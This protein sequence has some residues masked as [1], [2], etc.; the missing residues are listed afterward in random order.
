MAYFAQGARSALTRPRNEKRR[1]QVRFAEKY[2]TEVDN[3]KVS[4]DGSAAIVT[5][6]TQFVEGDRVIRITTRI[7]HSWRDWLWRKHEI[8]HSYIPN[9]T[10]MRCSESRLSLLCAA[11]FGERKPMSF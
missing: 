9:V 10:S 2:E 5:K 1:I 8:E 3:V 7:T 6:E 11:L 4:P